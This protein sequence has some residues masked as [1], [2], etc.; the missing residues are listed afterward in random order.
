[1]IFEDLTMLI[2]NLHIVFGSKPDCASKNDGARTAVLVSL[3]LS[4][5]MFGVKTTA[6]QRVASYIGDRKLLQRVVELLGALL[7]RNSIAAGLPI[8]IQPLQNL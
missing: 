1:M 8:D 7:I 6:V 2:L 4:V 5:F 3:M